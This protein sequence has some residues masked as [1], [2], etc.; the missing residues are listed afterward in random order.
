MSPRRHLRKVPRRCARTAFHAPDGPTPQRRPRG[1]SGAFRGVRRETARL[2]RR[3]P[4]RRATVIL[5]GVNVESVATITSP[6][7]FGTSAAVG[8][9]AVASGTHLGDQLGEGDGAAPEDG[10]AVRAQR[11]G[12]AVEAATHEHPS[13]R[14][15]AA[16]ARRR[17]RLARVGRHVAALA[18][19]SAWLARR[20]P[21]R[22]ARH[23]P[24]TR[25]TP[26]FHGKRRTCNSSARPTSRLEAF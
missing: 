7:T 3:A 18:R 9:A 19:A 15:P 8:L 20:P 14:P 13:I 6:P 5:E 2:G 4:I 16:R 23:W 12:L 1:A 22:H 24:R 10:G 25:P 26:R 17:L 11:P 21:A